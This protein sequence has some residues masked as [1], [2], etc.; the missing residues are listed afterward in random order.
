MTA[1]VGRRRG[2]EEDLL[3]VGIS[4]IENQ[5]RLS[6]RKGGRAS[7]VVLGRAANDSVERFL[8]DVALPMMFRFV[9]NAAKLR[10]PRWQRGAS[11][12]NL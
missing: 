5:N 12:R 6:A 8:S 11:S 4:M 10:D 7:D 1:A 2:E 9:Q 3:C